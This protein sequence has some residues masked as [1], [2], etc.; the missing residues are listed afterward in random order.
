[1]K[2][3]IMFFWVML[4]GTSVSMAKDRGVWMIDAGSDI[5]FGTFSYDD[6]TVEI[7]E[8]FWNP[9]VGIEYAFPGKTFGV[10]VRYSTSENSF[11][12]DYDNGHKTLDGSMDGE[13]SILLP[14]MRIGPRDGISLRVGASIYEYDFSNA[15]LDEVKEGVPTKKIREGTASAD[16]SLGVDV[17]LD[18]MFGDKFLFGVIIGAAYFPN[19][20]YDWQYRDELGDNQIKTGTAELDAVSARIGPEISYAV[21][22]GW[23]IFLRYLISGTSWLGDKDDEDEDYAGIDAMSAASIGVRADFGW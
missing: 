19:A 10:G 15:Y 6:A 20:D 12:L 23:R 22:D 1:M 4:A 18:M 8:E 5:A 13:R 11:E 3:R 14:Y 7:S 17:E 21:A 2:T 16:L 9:N